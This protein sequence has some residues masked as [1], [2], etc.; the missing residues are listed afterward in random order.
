MLSRSASSGAALYRYFE[1]AFAA[2]GYVRTYNQLKNRWSRK[3]RVI[4]GRS[5]QREKRNGQPR[6]LVTSARPEARE[7]V[8]EEERKRRLAEMNNDDDDDD[9]EDG[10]APSFGG[11]GTWDSPPTSWSSVASPQ[12][13]KRRL[14]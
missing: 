12:H 1:F 2:A 3:E 11:D 5:E 13:K 9:G 14:S 8:A 6:D 4:F 7:K 10:S